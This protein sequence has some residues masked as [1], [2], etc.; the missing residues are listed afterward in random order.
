MTAGKPSRRPRLLAA[1]AAGAMALAGTVVTAL[2]AAAAPPGCDHRTNDTVTK[3]L[4]CVDADGVTEHLKALQQIADANGGTRASGTPGFDA[5]AD[6]VQQRLEA[7][8][9]TVTRQS[10]DFPFFQLTSDS[11]GITAPTARQLTSGTDYATMSYSGSGTVTEAPVVPVDVVLPPPADPAAITSGCETSD[12]AGFPAGAVALVQRGTCSFAVKVANAQA[13]GAVAAV[14]FNSGQ[15]DVAGE[16]RTV[17][18]Q[19]T[20][21]EPGATIPAVGTTF[22]LGQELSAP[23]TR[24]SLS[25][26]ALSEVRQTANVLAELPGRTAE[27]V[28]VG[29]HL[30]SVPEGPGINDNGSGSAAVLEVAEAL[31]KAQ[32][33]RTVRFS[34]WGAEESGL[35]GSTH[36]VESLT[37]EEVGRITAY[38][39]F[40]M[41]A[42]PNYARFIYDGDGSTFP[43]PEG[44]VTDRS[45]AIETLFEEFYDSQG[46][47][48]EDTA[49]DGRSDYQAFSGAGVPSGGLFTGAEDVKTPEQAARY[50]GTA[51]EAFDPC[52]H[53]ACDDIG[54]VD[55]EVLDQ[56]VDAI[57]YATLTLAAAG[58]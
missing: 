2:P 18:L 43:A 20:L 6:Y 44:Y 46:L 34:W 4:R 9:Y 36:Y 27:V 10:F 15:T 42:S 52:Y 23:G 39:N 19:G 55:S 22:A 1:S 14:V 8:G 33:E 26:D 56:N 29:A 50:G 21:G 31:E 38:L 54:N 17:L 53:Q 47:T 49:F 12:F 45:A 58:Q 25:V 13:A 41:V 7:A 30:D 35:L 57:G 24:V 48:Y 51:G 40:D 32:L 3:L 37:P 16:D 28:Q 5:S 11:F